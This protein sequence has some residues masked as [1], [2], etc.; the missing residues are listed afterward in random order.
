MISIKRQD[1]VLGKAFL[2]FFKKER[3][4]TKLAYTYPESPKNVSED[5]LRPS[6]QFRREA[7]GVVTSIIT[8][9]VTF[10]LL[11]LA[12]TALAIACGYGGFWIITTIHNLWAIVFG[13]GLAGLGIMVLFFLFKF[14]FKSNTVD[15]SR[16]IEV[17]AKDQPILFDFIKRLASETH[18]ARPKRVYI[19][20]EVNACVFYNSSFWSMFLPVRKNLNIGLGLVN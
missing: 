11:I 13:V 9:I 7:V 6:A 14:I 15:R 12:A 8:F 18:T 5:L 19:S 16:M 10:L 17:T 3:P 2:L 4:M 20:P 1:L